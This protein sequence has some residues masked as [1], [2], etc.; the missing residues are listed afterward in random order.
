MWI[1]RASPPQGLDCY[2]H[3][4]FFPCNMAI[5]RFWGSEDGHFFGGVGAYHAPQIAQSIC[6]NPIGIKCT[7]PRICVQICLGLLA[8]IMVVGW[9][10]PLGSPEFALPLVGF[11]TLGVA[12]L[13]LLATGSS[14]TTCQAEDRAMGRGPSPGA[15]TGGQLHPR[16]PSAA[17]LPPRPAVPHVDTRA[18]LSGGVSGSL[19]AS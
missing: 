16:L 10:D 11:S 13:H 19:P 18:S 5:S 4:V 15:R 7:P 1:I 2:I 3:K 14:Q 12:G 8:P 9:Q 17:H 6:K